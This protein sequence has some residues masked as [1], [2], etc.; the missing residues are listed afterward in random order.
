V[1]TRESERLFREANRVMV[2]GV[3]SPVRSFSSVGGTPLFIARGEGPRIWDVDGNSFVDFVCSWGPLILGHSDPDVVEAAMKAA[4]S[5]TSFGAPT[6]PELRLAQQV[7]SAIPN[8]QKVRFVNSGT[9]ATMSALRLARAYTRRTRFVKFEGC[10]H[11]HADPFLT[12]AGSGLATLDLPSSAGVPEASSAVTLPYNDAGAVEE[13]FRRQGGEL[14]AVIVEPVAGNMGVIPPSPGFLETL[15]RLCTQNGSLLIFDEVIT[16]FRVSKG[17]AQEL[18]GVLPDITC[19]GKI[20]GGG[21]P[22]G[23]YGGRAEVMRLVAPEGPVY[24]AGTLSGNPVAMAAGLATLSKLDGSAYRRLEDTSARLEEGLSEAAAANG[25]E[26]VVNRVG[27]MVGLFFA[28]GEVKNY[29]HARASNHG[30]Y[31]EFHRR[32]LR[33]GFYLPPSPFETIF[34]STVHSGP[35]VDATVAAARR[36]FAELGR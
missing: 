13:A 19:L 17:G 16:G 34:L 22:V 10:Y 31:R 26:A 23:A 29:S 11:G 27:S 12:K 24:Q 8:I 33:E 15:E 28:R 5:G 20:I 6:V 1:E 35:D 9:E 3:N 14:S 32:M 21:F 4:R 7:C 30:L 18:Y 25:V 36:S 2:G